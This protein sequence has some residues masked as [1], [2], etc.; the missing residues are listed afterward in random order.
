MRNKTKQKRS[1]GRKR[2]PRKPKAKGRA[3]SAELLAL[4]VLFVLLAFGVAMFIGPGDPLRSGW[5]LRKDHH[6]SSITVRYDAALEM[7]LPE[8]EPEWWSLT[9]QDGERIGVVRVH[10]AEYAR[11]TVGE[12]WS[13]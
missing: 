7:T 12:R 1:K 11:A 9:L 3:G 2:G 13:R 4:V 8:A 5:V 6:P 10:Q